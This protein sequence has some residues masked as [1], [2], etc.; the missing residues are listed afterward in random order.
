MDDPVV[1]DVFIKS[2]KQFGLKYGTSIMTNE[3]SQLVC[4]QS[5]VP[6]FKHIDSIIPEGFS[7]LN[8]AIGIYRTLYYMKNEL[9][10]KQQPLP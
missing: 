8:S 9:D 10:S 4:L 6:Y 2:I 5:L 1:L 3:A 7:L